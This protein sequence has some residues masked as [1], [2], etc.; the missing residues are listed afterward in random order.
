MFVGDEERLDGEM[1]RFCGGGAGFVSWES[2]HVAFDGVMKPPSS[3]M[4]VLVVLD[5]VGHALS[6]QVRFCRGKLI[7]R[8]LAFLFFLFFLFFFLFLVFLPCRFPLIRLVRL[9]KEE[10]PAPDE[11]GHQSVAF[12]G[13]GQ[14]GEQVV[15][16]QHTRQ[17]VHQ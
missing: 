5:D 1:F 14:Q 7:G 10:F 2:M 16:T 6:S 4:D 13:G 12:L 9:K 17:T 11:Q 15:V 3:H 8:R